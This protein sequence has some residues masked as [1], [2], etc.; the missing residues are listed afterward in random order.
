MWQILFCIFFKTHNVLSSV[1]TALLVRWGCR[2]PANILEEV[3]CE[4]KI[5]SSQ[6]LSQGFHLRSDRV[7]ESAY[8][9]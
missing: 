3:L 9:N 6:V 1:C 4:N 5:G 7:H 2:I 8:D